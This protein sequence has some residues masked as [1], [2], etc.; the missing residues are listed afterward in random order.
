MSRLILVR[1]GRTNQDNALRF[2]GK[3]D[4]ELTADGVTQAEKLRDRLANEK[5]DTIY[6]SNLCRAR[7]TADIINS[8]HYLKI[9]NLAELN[10]IDF[11]VLEGLTFQEIQK[12]HPSVAR[13]L[14][15]WNIRNKFPDGESIDEVN[16]RLQKFLERL[17]T[18]KPEETVLIVAHGGTLRLL[19][20]NLLRIGIE[21]WRQLQINHSSL[22]IMETRPQG[23]MLNLFNDVSHLN[24]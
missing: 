12:L 7:S 2:W 10:E 24:R 17:N 9:T 1:H 6:A 3:T 22:S 4:V 21:H 5:I 19:I 8:R 15:D 13:D 23:A 11:G 20:C 14:D 18:H 16:S